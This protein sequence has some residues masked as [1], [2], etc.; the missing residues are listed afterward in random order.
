MTT[1]LTAPDRISRRSA[2]TTILDGLPENIDELRILIN[3]H[4]TTTSSFFDELVRQVLVEN[5]ACQLVIETTDEFIV[6]LA[7]D[8]AAV[9][10]VCDRLVVRWVE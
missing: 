7:T 5:R 3:D 1:T 8:A 4:P 6:E 10:A 2:V 9:H